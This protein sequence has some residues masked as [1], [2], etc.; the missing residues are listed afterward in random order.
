MKLRI[1]MPDSIMHTRVGPAS[2]Q[3][4][5]TSGLAKRGIEV[6]FDL[7]DKSFDV[8]LII[9]GTRKLRQ[10]WRCKRKGIPIIQ[11]LDGINWR[12]RIIPMNLRGRIIPIF[13][14][15]LLKL[16]R[17]HFANYVIYQSKFIQHWWH[18][19]YGPAPCPE[20]IIYNAVDLSSFYPDK[21]NQPFKK[22]IF[23]LCVEGNISSDE[24]TKQM[25]IKTHRYLSDRNIIDR[26]LIYGTLVSQMA[27]SLQNEKG[28]YL[29]GSVPPDDLP[30]IYRNA[31]LYL[32]LEIN[33]PCPNATI[34]A[35]ASGVPVIGFDTGSLA[36][37]ILPG[38]GAVVPYG[39]DPWKLEIPDISALSD[40]ARRIMEIHDKFSRDAR[41]L[42]EKKYDIDRM[43]E[44]YI[45]VFLKVMQSDYA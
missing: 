5:L 27:D 35:L 3:R 16:I 41:I 15:L 8:V 30:L 24:A 45:N 4:R 9:G 20:N 34:E 21:I 44:N 23:L 28:I 14:N 18:E 38:G 22:E 39:A 10:L 43:T 17:N 33:P 37:L 40:A 32:S 29:G 6:T 2:F 7:N 36:E 12:H 26:T 13:R 19:W 25:I 1:C 31:S 11:R 42:A